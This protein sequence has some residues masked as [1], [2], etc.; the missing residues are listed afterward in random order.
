MKSIRIGNDI[1]IVWPIVLSGDVSKLK[2]LDLVVE[3]RP[4]KKIIDTHNYADSEINKVNSFKRTETTILMNGGIVCR[5]DNGSGKE[6]CDVR[7]LYDNPQTAPVKL[8]YTIE[9]NTLIAIWPANKQFA[10]GDYDIVLYG[11]KNKG[12]Q[13]VCDQYRFV[14]LVSHTA[15]IDNEDNCGVEPVITMQP[16]TVELSGLSAYEVAV[17]EGFSGT[18]EEWVESLKQPAKDAASEAEENF[19][20][21][22][23]ETDKKVSEFVNRKIT[24]EMLSESTKQLI[25]ASGGG[26]ITNLADDEDITS[27]DDGTGSNVLKLKDRAYSPSTFSGKGYKI[28]RKNIV[29]GKNVLTQDMI[30]K[31]NTIYGVRYDFNLNNK[32]VMLDTNDVFLKYEGGKL[33]NGDIRMQGPNN[34]FLQGN[35]Y[36]DYNLLGENIKSRLGIINIPDNSI[37][38]SLTALPGYF[39]KYNLKGDGIT[40]DSINFNALLKDPVFDFIIRY[41]KVTLI[42]GRGYYNS[43]DS[44]DI[45][46]NFLFKNTINFGSISTSTISS[47]DLII[48]GDI[49]FDW[50]ESSSPLSLDELINDGT[51]KQDYIC[52]NFNAINY[53]NVL[54]GKVRYNSNGANIRPC[55]IN[56]G[57][58]T[59]PGNY[60]E[61]VK[62]KSSKLLYSSFN[63]SLLIVSTASFATING[64]IWENAYHGIRTT[65]DSA[66]IENVV[67]RKIYGDNGITCGDYAVF[68]EGV[69]E[70]TINGGVIVRNCDV[71]YCQDL[72]ISIQNRVGIV[73]NCI[74]KHC[75]NNNIADT[76]IYGI[77]NSFNNG[78]GI[79]VEIFLTYGSNIESLDIAVEIKNCVISDC[80]N[81]AIHSDYKG[82]I[83]NNCKISNIINTSKEEY[84]EN[85]K[86]PDIGI[87]FSWSI[88]RHGIISYSES[89]SHEKYPITVINTI[90]DS[91][92]AILCASIKDDIFIRFINCIIKNYQLIPEYKG[93]YRNAIL[94]NC[95]LYNWN[96]NLD[97]NFKYNNCVIG[98]NLLYNEDINSAYKGYSCFNMN[99]PIWWDGEKWIT[100]N[101]NRYDI[102]YNGSTS[103]RPTNVNTGFQYFDTDQN[104]PIYWTGSKWVDATGADC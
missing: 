4:S 31:E 57:R 96:F 48:E 60:Y 73:E 90:I 104:K 81:Y 12:G 85:R 9:N 32:T 8:T 62:T 17:L 49:R 100:A 23:L 74:I 44:S 76:S 66:I 91:D 16:T 86:S 38:F 67:V 101:G 68:E 36:M 21:Y 55:I 102:K 22:Q 61:G 33:N 47:L 89:L 84:S 10:T 29:D 25:A 99:K 15:Q 42:L 59:I 93:L 1:R 79:S 88:R 103:E 83:I 51:K 43:H 27:V 94:N 2:D 34:Y 14:R 39:S 37:C 87:Q 92:N 18:R 13:T 63:N 28:L 78:G 7:P 41:K 95:I 6:C 35:N 69:K 54:V 3:V 97:D 70:Y 53:V 80:Y 64:G 30:N 11:R 45:F 75:G 40:D 72:G 56:G 26:T 46:F 71:S 65:T 82:V 77:N 58:D 98:D 20:T 19:K 52:F 50:S 5:P 24:P